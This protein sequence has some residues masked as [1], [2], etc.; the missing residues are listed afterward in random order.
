MGG[1][2]FSSNIKM[3]IINNTFEDNSAIAEADSTTDDNEGKG[4]AIFL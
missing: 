2:I 3:S 4:G 1:A